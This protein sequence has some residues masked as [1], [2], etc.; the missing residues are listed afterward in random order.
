MDMCKQKAKEQ[1][2]DSAV[3]F[4]NTT[5]ATPNEF[6]VAPPSPRIKNALRQTKSKEVDLP[7]FQNHFWHERNERRPQRINTTR[8]KAKEC[9]APRIARGKNK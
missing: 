2:A 6:T 3:L 9:C 4:D 5:N 1:R 8:E 7:P